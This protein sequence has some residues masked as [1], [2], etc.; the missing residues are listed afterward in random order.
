VH[1]T[2][3]RTHTHTHTHIC[4]YA[5]NRDICKTEELQTFL[6]SGAS[7]KVTKPL[8]ERK[9]EILDPGH[10]ILFGCGLDKQEHKQLVTLTQQLKLKM[11][12]SYS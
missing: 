5:S 12:Q 3:A 9:V 4:I 10:V 11:V 7:V 6:N 2:H 1:A 8:V